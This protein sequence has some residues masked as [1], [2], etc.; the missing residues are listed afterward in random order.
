MILTKVFMVIEWVAGEQ[1]GAL[2][3]LP[4]R[5]AVIYTR[6]VTTYKI[7]QIT[8]IVAKTHVLLQL[9]RAIQ[10]SE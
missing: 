2:V 3:P 6:T 10:S 5:A 8:A 1:L 9:N 7:P 4:G